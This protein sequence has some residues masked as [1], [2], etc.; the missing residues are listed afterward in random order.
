VNPRRSRIAS[1]VV[2][3]AV[4][5]FW[6]LE[7]PAMRLYPGG[8]WWDAT[9]RGALFWQNFLCDLEWRVALDGLPNAVG[10][11]LAQAA[12][13]VMDLGMLPFWWLVGAQLPSRRRM[14]TAIRLLG[15]ISVSGTVAVAMLPSD[16]FAVPHAAA[17]ICAGLPGLSAA[18]I[19]V[20]GLCKEGAR[21]RAG[22]LLG[23]AML[24]AALSAFL[25]YASHVLLGTAGPPLVAAAQ[26]LALLL[27]QGWM[28]ATAAVGVRPLADR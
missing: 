13:L 26:K 22:A 19:G 2:V 10:S 23:G 14:G 4:V 6:A 5:A 1:A 9:T 20:V 7:V 3:A 17:V 28:V 11:R 15:T 12:M 18:V 24:A 27:L 8:T 25:M 21:G 16:H